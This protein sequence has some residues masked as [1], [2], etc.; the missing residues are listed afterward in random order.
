MLNPNEAR[1]RH[2]RLADGSLLLMRPETTPGVQVATIVVA[3]SCPVVSSGIANMLRRL[4]GSQFRVMEPLDGLPSE[5]A[6]QGNVIFVGDLAGV[7]RVSSGRSA[8]QAAVRSRVATVLIRTTAA[9]RA[10]FRDRDIQASLPIDCREEELLDTVGCLATVGRSHGAG[11][12]R[13]CGGLAPGAKRRL[14]EFIEA[15]V[16]RKIRIGTL[17]SMVGLSKEHFSRVFKQTFGSAPHRYILSLRVALAA[18]LI[19]TTERPLADVSLETGFA[20]QSHLTRT[21]TK[22]MGDTPSNFRRRHR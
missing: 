6:L 22:L 4:P 12:Q 2:D 8:A 11:F 16:T 17:A 15:N 21:F 10:V 9:D 20:D 19:R 18:S 3:H 13:A 1:I 5:P 7:D 14:R